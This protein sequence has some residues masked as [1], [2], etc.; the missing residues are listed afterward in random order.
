MIQFSKK[1]GLCG[2]IVCMF[3]STIERAVLM[4]ML[5][6]F[7]AADLSVAYPFGRDNY[8][9]NKGDLLNGTEG[10]QHLCP[11]RLVWARQH[12]YSPAPTQSKELTEFYM[13][14]YLWAVEEGGTYAIYFPN[15]VG[16][17]IRKSCTKEAYEAQLRL[18][19]KASLG[20]V[21]QL[22]R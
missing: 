1:R 8:R 15:G 9:R 14:W 6:Q 13:A 7:T 22:D 20:E 3:N 2:N 18:N 17:V 12:A 16:S 10:T 21:T 19:A 11:K 5:A 4:E